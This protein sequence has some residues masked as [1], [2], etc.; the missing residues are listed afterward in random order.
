MQTLDDRRKK[1]P[2]EQ[3]YVKCTLYL[4]PE[5]TEKLREEATYEGNSMSS[6][7]NDAIRKYFQHREA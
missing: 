5:V 2:W 4:E 6:V 3:K 7:V 1:V